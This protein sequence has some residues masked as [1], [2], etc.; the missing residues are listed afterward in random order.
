QM[1]AALL[2]M[3]DHKDK[4]T[5]YAALDAL[6]HTQLKVPP[7]RV[8]AFVK[9]VAEDKN[10]YLSRILPWVKGNEAAVLPVLLKMAE[11]D[12]DNQRF[13]HLYQQLDPRGAR[14]VLLELF[15]K[16]PDGISRQAALALSRLYYR[17]VT[18]NRAEDGVRLTKRLATIDRTMRLDLAM[19]II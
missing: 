7:E 15:D 5:R 14:P 2:K 4:E 19:S 11:P 6:Q 9:E 1:R 3:L 13:D 12:R 18:D 8:L 10:V 17:S 16:G